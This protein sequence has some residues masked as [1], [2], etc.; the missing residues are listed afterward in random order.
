MKKYILIVFLILIY[1]FNCDRNNSNKLTIENNKLTAVYYFLL[2]ELQNQNYT[3]ISSK[4]DENL[5]IIRDIISVFNLNFQIEEYSNLE[6]G[7]DLCYYSTSTKQM[8]SIISISE[9]T[10][11]SYYVSYYLG[12]EGGGSTVIKIIKREGKWVVVNEN[13]KWEIK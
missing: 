4:N 6:K 11:N 3:V 2:S 8:V 12:P 7:T 10:Q 13:E 5:D 9:R 1:F